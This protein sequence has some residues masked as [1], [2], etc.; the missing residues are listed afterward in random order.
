MHKGKL[1]KK[2]QDGSFDIEM[3]MTNEKKQNKKHQR[4]NDENDD[5]KLNDKKKKDEATNKT[6]SFIVQNINQLAIEP[7]GTWG[8][9]EGKGMY[10]VGDDEP[11]KEGDLVKFN[12]IS[13]LTKDE[14]IQAVRTIFPD[15]DESAGQIV[16]IAYANGSGVI[17]HDII[18]R[19]LCKHILQR[20]ERDVQR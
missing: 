16:S 14:F 20:N 6:N 10:W 7:T 17:T 12:C 1:V 3:P 5:D 19:R 4:E 8:I 15:L 2:H 18:T 13:F 11:F 9:V